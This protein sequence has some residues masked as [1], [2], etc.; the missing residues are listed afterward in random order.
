MRQR[1]G[2][3]IAMN[4][5]KLILGATMEDGEPEYTS[6][7]CFYAL[8]HKKQIEGIESTDDFG[9]FSTNGRW[10]SALACLA[11]ISNASDSITVLFGDFATSGS[12]RW[13]A[14][15][16]NVHIA[17]ESVKVTVH[18][19]RELPHPFPATWLRRLDSTDII[20]N[21]RVGDAA[22]CESPAIVDQY[23]VEN[24]I[25]SS[26]I[27]HPLLFKQCLIVRAT[28]DEL[29][30][31]ESFGLTHCS[32]KSSDQLRVIK[33]LLT[34][35]SAEDKVLLVG[36]F[37]PQEKECL[38][39]VA[40]IEDIRIDCDRTEVECYVIC[41]FRRAEPRIPLSQVKKFG[42]LTL[43]EDPTPG[44]FEICEPSW[45]INECLS[46][47]YKDTTV[48][49]FSD[50]LKAANLTTKQVAMLLHHYR[51]PEHIISMG[52]LAEMMGYKNSD[53]A[54]LH[55]GKLAARIGEL[56]GLAEDDYGNNINILAEPSGQKSSAGHLQWE[57]KAELARAL[58]QMGLVNT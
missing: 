41:D 15:V 27:P 37:D 25:T 4:G 23:L 53:A 3:E 39:W 18:C 17:D 50:A 28:L 40:T 13:I 11:N 10:D 29:L 21:L 6:S 46:L 58:E 56:L 33:D 32:L 16:H 22:L 9:E 30:D 49:E 26:Y 14:V 1:P 55:Y 20:A 57:M 51:A 7:V 12:A 52:Q 47:L 43:A 45:L 44:E 42:E 35:A 54:N 38:G 24:E 31:A 34:Q 8:V 48:E 5:G 2:G 36:F 19:L